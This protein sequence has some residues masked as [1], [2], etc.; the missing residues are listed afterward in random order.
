MDD[1]TIRSFEFK[2]SITNLAKIRP[3]QLNPLLKNINRVI[4]FIK[5][6]LLFLQAF[7]IEAGV[8]ERNKDLSVETEG[9]ISKFAKK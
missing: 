7:R 6:K 9:F 2:R 5:G 1:F 4:M 8:N 3:K